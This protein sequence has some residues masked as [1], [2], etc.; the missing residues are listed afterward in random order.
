MIKGATATRIDHVMTRLDRLLDCTDLQA[1]L[2]PWRRSEWY[3]NT[4][5]GL[6]AQLPDEIIR[7]VTLKPR[8]T[9]QIEPDT[10]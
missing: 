1:A 7:F 4:Q 5:H 3:T 9:C 8:T 2:Q 6:F 10:R